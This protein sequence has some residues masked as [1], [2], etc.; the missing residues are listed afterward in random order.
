MLTLV[1][2]CPCGLP[3]PLRL[4]AAPC[5]CCD[6]SS[7]WPVSKPRQQR[8]QWRQQCGVTHHL[9]RPGSG[10]CCLLLLLLLL[11]AA[12]HAAAWVRPA[13]AEA[14]L[15]T[16]LVP[17]LLLGCDGRCCCHW[18]CCWQLVSEVETGPLYHCHT[19]QQECWQQRV[20]GWH[21][22]THQQQLG[23][24]GWPA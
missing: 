14:V 10:P 17:L 23:T 15:V 5:R 20:S 3:R 1:H 18:H 16:L 6:G 9:G 8:Q 11:H 19:Q 24:P 2:H 7:A 12:L 21:G 4:P 13:A 22:Q